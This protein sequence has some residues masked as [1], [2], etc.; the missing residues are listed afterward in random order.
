MHRAP[1]RSTREERRPSGANE[2][3]AV[4]VRESR[5]SGIAGEHWKCKLEAL[6]REVGDISTGQSTVGPISMNYTL[7]FFKLRHFQKI[8]LLILRKF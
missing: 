1:T 4:E 7:L 2:V 6:G 8:K 3:S 5:V